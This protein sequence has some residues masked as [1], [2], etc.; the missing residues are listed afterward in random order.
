MHG[1]GI[2]C[3]PD[4]RLAAKGVGVGGVKNGLSHF[5]KEEIVQRRYWTCP[6]A[7]HGSGKPALGGGGASSRQ[8]WRFVAGRGAK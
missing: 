8:L 7:G 2:D 1:E 4:G 6:T 5:K 3:Q